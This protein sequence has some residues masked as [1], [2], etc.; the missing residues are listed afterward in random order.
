MLQTAYAAG[1]PNSQEN[2]VGKGLCA[3][4]FVDLVDD[5]AGLHT[6][7]VTNHSSTRSTLGSRRSTSSMRSPSLFDERANTIRTEL[8]IARSAAGVLIGGD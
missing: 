7:P 6:L 2:E 3:G 5:L 8:V 4:F 1:I